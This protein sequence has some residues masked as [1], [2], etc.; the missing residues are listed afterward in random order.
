MIQATASCRSPDTAGRLHYVA[1]EQ[2]LVL[3]HPDPGH[4][5]DVRDIGLAVDVLVE[6]DRKFG[7][8]VAHDLHEQVEP[9]ATHIM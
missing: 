9:A 8:L 1:L 5:L 4:D 7:F 3:E 2:E 6:E